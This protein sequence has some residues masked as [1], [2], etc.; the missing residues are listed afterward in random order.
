[1]MVWCGRHTLVWFG[2]FLA[3]PW[4]THLVSCGAPKQQ[5]AVWLVR[6]MGRCG[7]SLG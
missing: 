1:M 7:K 2:A 6:A 3:L 4:C 5:E